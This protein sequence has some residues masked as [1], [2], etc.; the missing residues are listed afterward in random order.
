MYP[1]TICNRPY[2]WVRPRFWPISKISQFDEIHSECH[3]F[4]IWNIWDLSIEHLIFFLNTKNTVSDMCHMIKVCA[5][6]WKEVVRHL[7]WMKIMRITHLFQCQ[8]QRPWKKSYNTCILSSQGCI[9]FWHD[10]CCCLGFAGGSTQL[11]EKARRKNMDLKCK[12]DAV[13]QQIP[14]HWHKHAQESAE[15]DENIAKLRYMFAVMY[16]PWV[17]DG[18]FQQPCLEKLLD[19]PERFKAEKA[20]EERIIAKLY[21]AV[22]EKLH[23]MLKD[24]CHYKTVVYLPVFL[25]HFVCCQLYA[26]QFTRAQ[27]NEHSSAVHHLWHE[28]TACIFSTCA[29]CL[30]WSRV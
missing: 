7:P 21:D 18:M 3:H 15:F 8:S 30:L 9:Y 4:V 24:Q 14:K 1:L 10:R 22:P 20:K 5:A 23:W 26:F 27:G 25:L 12:L 28:C 29:K 11:T 17:K 16:E 19:N 2:S 6:V 13:M